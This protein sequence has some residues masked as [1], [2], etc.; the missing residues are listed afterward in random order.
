M[1]A[2]LVNRRSLGD[3]KWISDTYKC[4][5]IGD[6]EVRISFTSRCNARCMTCLVPELK[7][8]YDLPPELFKKFIN[9]LL[10]LDFPRVLV[11][12]FGIGESYLHK[13]FVELCEWAI[14]LIHAKGWTT[15]IVTNGL[16]TDCI[17]KGLDNLY[18]SFNAGKKESYE[19]ITGM[20]FDKVHKNILSLYSN[21]ELKKAK[22]T[23][24]HMLCFDK[25]RGEEEDFKQ[26]FSG[27][28]GVKLR[29]SYKYDN[30]Q[31]NT[32]GHSVVDK[33]RRIACDYLTSKINLYP[34]GDIN[35][36]AHDF[37]GKT[38]FGNIADMPLVEILRSRKRI[39]LVE[40]HL[41]CTFHGICKECDYNCAV[42]EFEE[43]P[44]VYEYSD[45]NDE[46][47]EL[48]KTLADSNRSFALVKEQND[49]LV[50][51]NEELHQSYNNSLNDIAYLK[52]INCKL[53]AD[54]NESKHFNI[55]S[56]VLRAIIM[57][58]NGK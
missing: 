3:E 40:E 49:L 58:K 16:A 41:S 50:K 29:Y 1:K 13:N 19:K 11:S 38:S 7:Q 47:A 37:H 5:M 54:L 9:E 18:L 48:K 39:K 17:P 34:T 20:N 15:S 30:Q 12:F 28:Q 2:E 51:D 31:N 32:D 55:E 24:I 33:P 44:F 42:Q 46:I 23:E 53:Q 52:E 21:G 36:C 4:G 22:N 26:L 8:R 25:N 10:E 35:L 43:N 57:E 27:M 56:Q 14:P 45:P 6:I